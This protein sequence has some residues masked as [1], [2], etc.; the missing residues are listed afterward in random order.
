[1]TSCSVFV[2]ILTRFEYASDLVH[3]SFRELHNFH[4]SRSRWSFPTSAIASQASVYSR[5]MDSPYSRAVLLQALLFSSLHLCELIS[6]L[7]SH[8]LSLLP[9]HFPPP[10]LRFSHVKVDPCLYPSSPLAP[11][12]LPPTKL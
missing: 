4:L 11:G 2:T 3:H 5:C 10:A 12:L 9:R 1:M 6:P 7:L 8:L